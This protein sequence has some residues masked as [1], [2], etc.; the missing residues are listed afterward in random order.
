METVILQFIGKQL[1]AAIAKGLGD[2]IMKQM[3]LGSGAEVTKKLDT[4]LSEIKSLKQ[5]VEDL[6]KAFKLST[7]YEKVTAARNTVLNSVDNIKTAVQFTNQKL[8]DTTIADLASKPSMLDLL[9]DMHRALAEEDLVGVTGNKAID[10]LL[11]RAWNKLQDK[12]N[13]KYGVR[14]FKKEWDQAWNTF[15]LIQRVGTMLYILNRSIQPKQPGWDKEGEMKHIV[16]KCNARTDLWW[17]MYTAWT[18]KAP[19]YKML[20]E[21][22]ERQTDKKAPKGA[23]RWMLQTNSEK[24][25]LLSLICS[26]DCR[27]EWSLAFQPTS[28]YWRLEGFDSGAYG[29]PSWDYYAPDRKPA[30][31]CSTPKK[32][33][34]KDHP[35]WLIP[36]DKIL[37]GWSC[38]YQLLP[39]ETANVEQAL[40]IIE[41]NRSWDMSQKIY[42]CIPTVMPYSPSDDTI[43]DCI[44][45]WRKEGSCNF[46][47]TVKNMTSSSWNSFWYEYGAIHGRTWSPFGPC[48]PGKNTFWAGRETGIATGATSLIA[49]D[50]LETDVFK[51]ASSDQE[52]SDIL[53]DIKSFQPNGQLTLSLSKAQFAGTLI[54]MVHVPFAGPNK[55]NA[56]QLSPTDKWDL[57][58]CTH[59]LSGGFDYGPGWNISVGPWGGLKAT[60]GVNQGSKTEAEIHV[61]EK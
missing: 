16:D 40:I 2:E 46:I 29:W 59:Q 48:L 52:L 30:I 17:E 54:M 53:C 58:K 51:G 1:G 36:A 57:N 24:T 39:F 7:R 37:E 47:C 4:L 13:L 19:A 28:G 44:N 5:D 27:Q 3:G 11:G 18:D 49:F 34:R 25:W 55:I 9:N 21:E 60:M 20:L 8:L 56:V 14:E 43:K 15:V 26:G 12:G 45:G 42:S 38:E 41:T 31:L 33:H 61:Y 32:D 22:V 6:D 35:N 23:R 50:I 10:C